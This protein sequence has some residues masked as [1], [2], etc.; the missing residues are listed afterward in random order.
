[1]SAVTDIRTAVSN[2]LRTSP[3][4]FCLMEQ[5]LSTAGLNTAASLR[6]TGPLIY[7]T[8]TGKITALFFIFFIFLSTT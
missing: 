3:L 5:R 6:Y 2:K 7:I 1:M 4:N 8:A